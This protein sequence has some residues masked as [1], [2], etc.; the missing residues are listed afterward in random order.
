[1][2]SYTTIDEVICSRTI[3][4]YILRRHFNYTNTS[5]TLHKSCRYTHAV[6]YHHFEASGKGADGYPT[7]KK[8]D[9]LHIVTITF[10]I[11]PSIIGVYI[12]KNKM[13]L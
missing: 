3:A 4:I 7:A 5:R 9:H 1:M 13:L 8:F 10:R 2:R 6:S 12:A 11:T